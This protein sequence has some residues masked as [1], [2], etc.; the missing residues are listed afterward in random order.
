[1]TSGR[2]LP[3]DRGEGF[4]AVRY[5]DSL[6]VLGLFPPV[7]RH[8]IRNAYR[9]RAGRAHPDRVCDPERKQEATERIQEINAA[10]D[11]AM[12][13]YRMFDLWQRRAYRNGSDPSGM[14]VWVEAALSPAVV[15]HA[16]TTLVAGVAAALARP[17]LA[18][19][20]GPG[21]GGSGRKGRAAR[22][23][24]LALMPHVLVV[25]A[26]VAVEASL[27]EVWLGVT[28]LVMIATDAASLATG[29]SNPLRKH[30]FLSG[31]FSLARR[32]AG[33]SS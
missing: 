2:P 29:E 13:H 7:A 33:S 10:R 23:L 3:A 15:V 4:D 26:F 20:P 14:S 25:A 22:R 5:R 30:R 9:W 16:V 24:W 32:M 31:A 17:V 1:M 21:A 12:R 6:K 27:L 18:V 8:D 19:S 11:Y 28:A